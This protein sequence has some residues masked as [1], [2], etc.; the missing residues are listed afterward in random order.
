[1]KSYLAK[2]RLVPLVL[3]FGMILLIFCG[4][5]YNTQ[6]LNGSDYKARSL[7]S[8]ATAQTVEASRGI[9][10]DRNGKVLIS[11]R[12][13]YTL[14]FSDEEFESDTDCNDAIFRLLELCRS[15]NVKWTDTLPVSKEP[16]FTYTT[17]T[18]EGAFR[19][20]LESEDLPAITVGTL[21]PTQE[22][23]L[24]MAQLRKLYGVADSYSDTDARAII[25]VRYQLALRDIAGGTYTFASDVSVELINQVVD[26]RYAGVTTGT[27]SARVYDTTYAAHVLGRLSPIYQEDW[28]GDP[29]NGIVGYRDKGY[30]MDALVGES[31]VEKAFEEYLH[32][33]NGTKL[34][35][36]TSDGQITGEFYTK[37]PKPGNT[38]ALTLDIDL[39]EDVEK[40]LSKTI[41]DMTEKD[42][43]RRGG[44]AVVVGVGSG[45]VLALASY[46]TYDIS[47]W[48]EIYDTL[49]SDDKGAPLFNRAIG[50][51]YAPGS[52][53]KPAVAVAALYHD[54]S[55][56][57]TGDMPTP[58]KYDNPAI[59]KAY[60][61]VEAVA[62][63]KLLHMLPEEFQPVYA[64][65]LTVTD[66]ETERLVKAADKLSAYIKCVEE[67][68]AGNSEFRDAAAQTRAA[69]EGYGLPEVAYFLETFMPSFSLTLDQLK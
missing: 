16:P 36:T 39:Q 22:A 67:L 38:V 59:R 20:Y 18:D 65:I 25:G 60:K 58:I 3:I 21:R 54:A 17:P 68:K 32:G 34:I 52:P 2:S 43:I 12:L 61:E 53:F 51:T 40:A 4:V 5:L 15:N 42:G 26:G 41:G 45:E 8:N 44:A 63:E 10:T 31:G 28:V 24:F 35:T 66:P 1:M 27:A 30:S 19:E 49:A 29:D 13:T 69:L 47:K 9:I 46:P 23:P 56:I 57:L 62:E 6:I 50:G 64:P 7:A 48:D 14:V 55:E 11:N 33:E 37:E